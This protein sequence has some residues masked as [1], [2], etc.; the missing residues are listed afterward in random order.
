MRAAEQIGAPKRPI[1]TWGTMNKKKIETHK[2]GLV[3]QAPSRRG[4]PRKPLAGPNGRKIARLA[5]MS[6]D[7]LIACRRKHLN[8]HYD[9]TRGK[10]DAFDHPK[11][12]INAANVLLDWRVERIV[13]L[14]KNV[15]RCFGFRELPFLAEISIYGRRFLIFPHPS[16]INRWWN[17]RRNERRARQ[18]LQRFLRGETIRDGFRK[19][20]N[21]TAPRSQRNSTG[22]A[23]NGSRGTISRRSL[24]RTSRHSP[25]PKNRRR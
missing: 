20:G 23:A 11:G 8:T 13:L 3:G 12:N 1:V 24:W 15:A 10:G 17:E 4:D 25:V 19:S 18:L 21:S 22:A 9:G 5:G 14:G 7:E 16:G 6:Y 2:I